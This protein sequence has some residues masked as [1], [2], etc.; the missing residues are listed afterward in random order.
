MGRYPP[1]SESPLL[2]EL[3]KQFPK[4]QVIVHSHCPQ[5]TYNKKMEK[6][7][8][9]EYICY[10]IFGQSKQVIETLKANYGFAILRLHGEISLGG[11]TSE[12]LDKLEGK[13]VKINEK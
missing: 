5:I 10:G 8:T 13:L 7:S 1:S 6:Y 9:D 2:L 11:S 12:V 4:A 3:F